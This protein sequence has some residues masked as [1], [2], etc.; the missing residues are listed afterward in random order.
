MPLPEHTRALLDAGGWHLVGN[1]TAEC[2]GSKFHSPTPLS[3]SSVPLVPPEWV[4]PNRVPKVLLCGTCRENLSV[5][6]Q[7]LTL[8]NGDV[9]WQVRREFGNTIRALA[10]KGW[11]MYRDT[12]D[13]APSTAR[14]SRR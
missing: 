10:D 14:E 9:P 12:V 7:I 11:R 6:Q 3:V 1:G 4:D 5:I 8:T 2:E 13:D